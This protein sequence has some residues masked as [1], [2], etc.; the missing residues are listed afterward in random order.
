MGS[1]RSNLN[2]V[3]HLRARL[4][5]DAFTLVGEDGRRQ[6]L[7]EA[8]FYS[9]FVRNSERLRAAYRGEDVPPP[10]P[11]GEALKGAVNPL[12]RVLEQAAENQRRLD[13]QIEDQSKQ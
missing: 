1:V 6:K 8:D 4:K 11:V 10:H 7:T 13:K 12:P 3:R 5:G 9:N 2:A